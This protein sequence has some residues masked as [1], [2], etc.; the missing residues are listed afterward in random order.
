MI[1]DHFTEKDFTD[2][3]PGPTIYARDKATFVNKFIGW[4]KRGFPRKGMNHEFIDQLQKCF[5]TIDYRGDTVTEYWERNWQS[6][7]KR[8][9]II[10]HFCENQE[11]VIPMG[12]YNMGD[13]HKAI[14]RWL[15]ANGYPKK[16]QMAAIYHKKAQ[17]LVQLRKD[18]FEQG[19][20]ISILV[21][22]AESIE[23]AAKLYELLSPYCCPKKL[24]RDE[25]QAQLALENELRKYIQDKQWDRNK[26]GD[27]HI[28]KRFLSGRFTFEYKGY[29]VWVNG[30]EHGWAHNICQPDGTYWPARSENRKDTEE[31]IVRRAQYLIDSHIGWLADPSKPYFHDGSGSIEREKF[32]LLIG[33]MPDPIVEEPLPET[34][35]SDDEQFAL[36]QM[37]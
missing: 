29:T 28:E 23:D 26:N 3:D 35:L 10:K 32:Y 19:V 27:A 13:A 30:D 12:R 24:T 37:R 2:T 11:A 18:I 20:P 5:R 16:A 25:A 8:D 22:F 36:A 33:Q 17:K 7:V 9:D 15:E 1:K 34:E 31:L 21:E 6:P 14:Y 4:A